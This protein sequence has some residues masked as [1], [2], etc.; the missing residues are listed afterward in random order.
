MMHGQ[1][2]IKLYDTEV[3]SNLIS[4]NSITNYTQIFKIKE[5]RP[6]SRDKSKIFLPALHIKFGLIKISEKAMDK[7][8]EEFF[9]LR[10]K[11]PQVSE[12][13]MKEGIFVGPQITLFDDQHFSTKLTSTERRTW[14]VF[15]NVF[16]NFLVNEKA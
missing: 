4:C 14:K 1:K 5:A 2:T 11:F 7:E 3:I 10:Q 13:K 16:R 6:A 8:S 9:Y 15:E 12:A